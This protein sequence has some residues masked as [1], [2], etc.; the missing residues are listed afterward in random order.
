MQQDTFHKT[1]PVL[2]KLNS[3]D[4]LYDIAPLKKKV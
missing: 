1:I 3:I 4:M 2:Y